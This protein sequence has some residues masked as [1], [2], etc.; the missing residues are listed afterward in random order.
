MKKRTSFIKR[1]FLSLIIF[2]IVIFI[3]MFVF[4]NRVFKSLY[5]RKVI[6]TTLSEIDNTFDNLSLSDL[7]DA[8][9]DFSQATQTSTLIV[10]SEQLKQDISILNFLL[11]EVEDDGVFYNIYS[12]NNQ[13]ISNQLGATIEATLYFHPPSGN[14]VPTSLFINDRS[15]LRSMGNMNMQYSQLVDSLDINT[16]I[17]ISGTISDINET[18]PINSNELNPIAATEVLNIISNNYED[19]VRTDDGFYYTSTTDDGEYSNLVFY[20]K[21]IVDGKSVILIAVYP[22]SHIDDIVNAMKLV[23]LYLFI[24]VFVVLVVASLFYSKSFSSPISKLNSATKDISILNFNTEYLLKDRNDEFGELSDNISLLSEN[25]ERTLNTLQIQN[26]QLSSSLERENENEFSRKNFVKGLSH[27]I[28]TPLAIIQASSEAIQ[29]NIFENDED[30]NNALK[31]I[32]LEVKRTNNI[33]NSMMQVYKLDSPY[34]KDS[35]K[36]I[37]LS[38][39]ITTLVES[40]S[41]LSKS[42]NVSINLDLEDSFIKGDTEKIELVFSNLITNAIKY[43]ENNN[44]V[45]ITLK[46]SGEYVEFKIDNVTDEISIDELSHLFNPFYKI[47]KS[48]DRSQNSTGLGLYIVQA[49]LKQYGSICETSYNNGRLQFKF[50]IKSSY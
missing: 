28:K 17:V 10:P 22:L 14:Y 18:K 31:S 25:L 20:E 34:Y 39:I 44:D 36:K 4:Q 29:N 26:K 2:Y 9:V 16:K 30:K 43:T 3:G 12:P 6:N 7:N 41:V 40:L 37:E 46:N 47:D 24:I 32:Q 35:W 1:L 27:E 45:N 5:T 33:V 42:R 21:S 15:V 38:Q 8:V 11:L 48:G 19:A 50:Q 13:F 49:T 23:N